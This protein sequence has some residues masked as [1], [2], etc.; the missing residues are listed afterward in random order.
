MC[1][2]LRIRLDIYEEIFSSLQ[3]E[4]QKLIT[5]KNGTVDEHGAQQQHKIL[6][7]LLTGSHT[8]CHTKTSIFW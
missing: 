1:T 8:S 5:A 4:P 7:T 6:L 3:Q 2:E